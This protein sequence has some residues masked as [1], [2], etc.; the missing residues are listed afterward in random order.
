MNFLCSTPTPA[1]DGTNSPPGFHMGR[2]PEKEPL[3]W[4]SGAK[5]PERSTLCYLTTSFSSS[6]AHKCNHVC[7]KISE[8]NDKYVKEERIVIEFIIIII[9]I[10]IEFFKVA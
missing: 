7:V 2:D 4:G 6:S 3:V 5:P 10:I 1:L 8:L 9:I